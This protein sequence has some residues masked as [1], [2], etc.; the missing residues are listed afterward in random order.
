MDA[1]REIEALRRLECS[2]GV[3]RPVPLLQ[4]SA[5]L[6]PGIFG[7]FRPVLLWP[8]GISEHLSDEHLEAILAHEL[9]HV[10]YRDNLAAAAQS[11]VEAIFWFHPL[12]W[13]IGA[14][15]VRERERGCDEEVLAMG[16]RP[17]PTPKAF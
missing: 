1:G 14:Q 16:S 12:V 15:M 4:T 6:E 3:R 2:T 8:E 11:L 7:I 17:E 5:A 13:W 10:H 9:R